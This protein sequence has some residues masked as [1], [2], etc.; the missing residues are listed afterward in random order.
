M[1]DEEEEEEEGDSS[2]EKKNRKRGW[3]VREMWRQ[4]P[5]LLFTFTDGS[6]KYFRLF[7]GFGHA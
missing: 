2:L 3:A 5:R 1:E 4:R 7:R 6:L